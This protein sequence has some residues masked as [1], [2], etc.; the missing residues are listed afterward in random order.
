MDQ[1][2]LDRNYGGILILFDRLFGSFQAETAW[3]HYGLTKQVDT[4]NIWTLQTLEYVAIARD[5]RHA[6]RWRD[7]FGYIFGPPGW[8]PAARRAVPESAELRI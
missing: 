4:Y 8:V 1:Q 5:V 7:R 6:T 3:P 2:Y